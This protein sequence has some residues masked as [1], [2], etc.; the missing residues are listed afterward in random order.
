[1]VT[2]QNESK[3]LIK[4]FL[5]AQIIFLLII[6]LRSAQLLHNLEIYA[7]DHFVVWK[8]EQS[9]I[10]SRIVL[11]GIDE[12]DFEQSG[13]P[14]SDKVLVQLLNEL[15]VLKPK[16]I[17]LDL[18]RDKPIPNDPEI[19]N[20]P[21][22]ESLNRLLNQQSNIIGIKNYS[23]VEAPPG[24]ANTNRVGINDIIRDQNAVVRRSILYLKANN[25]IHFSFPYLLFKQFT[26]I[27][28]QRDPQDPDA[29][30]LDKE[31]IV[32]FN[33]TDGGY[34]EAEDRG[35]QFLLDYRGGHQ[36]FPMHS[37]TDVLSRK[38]PNNSMNAKIV[39]VGITAKSEKDF[40]TSPFQTTDNQ[41][42]DLLGI[43]LLGHI[44]SQLIRIA[45]AESNSLK[46]MSD[47]NEWSYIWIASL[48]GALTA[49]WLRRMA[50][51][52]SITLVQLLILYQLCWIAFI[53]NWWLPLIPTAI[54]WFLSSTAVAIYRLTQD[55]REKQFL[56]QIYSPYLP[57]NVAEI[58]WQ[59]R[60]KLLDGNRLR[61]HNLT[62]TVLFSD[63]CDFSP[64]AE[65]LQPEELL[66]WLNPYMQA[67][68]KTVTNHNGM[69]NKMIGDGIMAVFGAPVKRTS[70]VE[71]RED[72]VNAATCALEMGKALDLLN[73][74]FRRQNLPQMKIRIGIMTGPLVA[75]SIGDKERL[76]YTVLGDTVNIAARLE[77]HDK[78]SNHEN[79]YRILL[80]KST[81][82]YLSKYFSTRYIGQIKLKGKS[83]Q[84]SVYQLIDKT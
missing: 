21:D 49:Y 61:P 59:T 82:A 56:Q 37:M 60:D 78:T 8:A 27:K 33:K 70:E 20:N 39:I 26:G 1:M 74:D 75:G 35:H 64:V 54:A 4:C 43:A 41:S 9:S 62:A 71:I 69:V 45:E 66:N 23:G 46:T 34:I 5:I 13:W 6:S 57:Q 22:F 42:Q 10:D 40:F 76:E 84:V 65:Q 79:T 72:A 83:E 17:G 47:P 58:L 67:M 25:Q 29:I 11:V 48:V 50:I 73:K 55:R 52:I 15:I 44:T 80:G 3:R 7:Y 32:R 38:I 12:P 19:T 77:S 63:I 28:M 16:V 30:T 14:L 36:S 18:Y 68:L 53:Y 81:L 24:L 31:R 2:K 51:L